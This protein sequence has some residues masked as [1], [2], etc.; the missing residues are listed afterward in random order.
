MADRDEVL[1]ERPLQV[2]EDDVT[3]GASHQKS[4]SFAAVH[5]F[6]S[7][8]AG[9]RLSSATEEQQHVFVFQVGTKRVYVDLRRNQQGVYLKLSEK[10]PKV[11]YTGPASWLI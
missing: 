3:H 9:Y 6:A 7:G 11:S 2:H 4:T 8:L 10:G 5:P 1:F